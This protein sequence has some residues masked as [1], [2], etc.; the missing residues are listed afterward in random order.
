MKKCHELVKGSISNNVGIFPYI[1]REW[2]CIHNPKHHKF[3]KKNWKTWLGVAVPIIVALI[4][5][6]SCL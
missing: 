2:W 4:V 3:L 5:S 1:Y 6:N